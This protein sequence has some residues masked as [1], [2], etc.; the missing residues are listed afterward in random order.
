[1]TTTFGLFLDAALTMPLDL[2]QADRLELSVSTDASRPS[3]D[4]VIYL[5][6]PDATKR[7]RA[8]SDPGVDTLVLSLDDSENAYDAF[9]PAKV[10]LAA[11]Q[12]GLSSATPGAA[13]DTGVT[14]L[15]GGVANA[16]AIHIRVSGMGTVG[17][18]AM[19][20]RCN[21]LAEDAA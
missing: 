14:T 16:L 6:S 21:E 18:G 20:I 17:Q 15:M 9:T 8:S 4:G 3:A 1:M 13:L 12:V 19:I 11:T 5:G 2:A 7:A 10:R